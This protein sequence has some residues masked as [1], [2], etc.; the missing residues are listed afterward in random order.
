MGIEIE[1]KD[2]SPKT[3]AHRFERPD[4]QH[5][6]LPKHAHKRESNFDVN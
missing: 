5:R 2:L 6:L 4:E 3:C 1:K